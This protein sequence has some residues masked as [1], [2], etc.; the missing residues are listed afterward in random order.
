MGRPHLIGETDIFHFQRSLHFV[1]LN[2][3]HVQ[4]KQ[5]VHISAKHAS[6]MGPPSSTSVIAQSKDLVQVDIWQR[7]HQRKHTLCRRS[8]SIYVYGTM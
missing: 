4:K 1:Y 3:L 6:M 5:S 8:R 7:V 2:P